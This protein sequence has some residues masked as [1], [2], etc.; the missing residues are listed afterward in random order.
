MAGIGLGATEGAIKPATAEIKGRAIFE[1]PRMNHATIQT[2][3]QLLQKG[4]M[5]DVVG[6]KSVVNRGLQEQILKSVFGGNEPR[7]PPV[8]PEEQQLRDVF[9]KIKAQLQDINTA[10]RD[11][12]I[13]I[14][15]A[16]PLSAPEQMVFSTLEQTVMN[17]NGLRE[18]YIK[19]IGGP[20]NVGTPQAAEV[21]QRIVRKG[22]FQEFARGRLNEIMIYQPEFIGFDELQAKV[23]TLA[24]TRVAKTAALTAFEANAVNQA[25]IAAGVAPKDTFTDNRKFIQDR[26]KDSDSHVT[27][28][29]KQYKDL[30][31]EITKKEIELK[32]VKAGLASGQVVA[33]MTQ[34]IADLRAQTGTIDTDILTELTSNG[35][36]RTQ[37]TAVENDYNFAV[38]Y[39]R[40]QN[41]AK[42]TAADFEKGNTDLQTA[43]G[44]IL[45]QAFEL[46]GKLNGIFPAAAEDFIKKLDMQLDSA[47]KNLQQEEAQ[48]K[49][50]D[51]KKSEDVIKAAEGLIIDAMTRRYQRPV[52]R[53]KRIR[54]ETDTKKLAEDFAKMTKDGK[55]AFTKGLIGDGIIGSAYGLGSGVMGILM[56]R[57]EDFF[58]QQ[59]LTQG[60]NWQIFGDAL[61]SF[62]GVPQ[63]LQTLIGRQIGDAKLGNA[64]LPLQVEI[65]LRQ[66]PE[67][68]KK[69]VEQVQN[70]VFTEVSRDAVRHLKL[71]EKSLR[72]LA[73]SDDF[74]ASA[75]L[76]ASKMGEENDLIKSLK[77]QGLTKKKWA[78]KIEGTA[79]GSLMSLMYAIFGLGIIRGKGLFDDNNA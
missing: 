45:K 57:V 76:A 19:T 58:K 13:D 38:Q 36:L 30:T 48:Q 17:T 59:A 3:E 52:G 21:L 37:L 28:L 47:Y 41:E 55:I 50:E 29:R 10:I 62:A 67:A 16:P 43:R 8:T 40:L 35:V 14:T 69:L 20:A 53:G 46:E 79:F 42:T 5:L 7:T 39:E 65:Y 2:M 51:A 18:I 44:K 23:N 33:D 22:L 32:K 70:R 54:Y 9:N 34:D 63:E 4:G 72:T 11:N 25:K 60:G 27:E 56:P 78:E 68:Q 15:G 31:S 77:K 71:D 49:I 73:S 12:N 66:H 74:M 6:G 26:I 64:I 24:A 61:G 75:Q 1:K